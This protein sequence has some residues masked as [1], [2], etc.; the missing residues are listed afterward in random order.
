MINIIFV[1]YIRT[2]LLFVLFLFLCFVS[3]SDIKIQKIPDIYIFIILLLGVIINYKFHCI[4]LKSIVL[5][6][7]SIGG[8]MII[9][10]IIWNGCFGGGDIKLMIVSSVF[11]G[12]KY[13]WK[14]FSVGVIF[15][16]PYALW[17]LLKENSDRHFPIGP[18]LSIGIFIQTIM[19][20]YKG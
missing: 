8:F 5:G 10:A 2:V 4:T 16:L 9:S 15:A 17:L 20:V 14:A 18:Y 1:E 13:T 11:L 3:L 19:I 12:F 7:L 6:C